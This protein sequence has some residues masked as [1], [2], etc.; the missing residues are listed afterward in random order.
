MRVE[1]SSFQRD[2]VGWDKTSVRVTLPQQEVDAIT[3]RRNLLTK[4][5]D[6][7]SRRK[8]V[9]A[10]LPDVPP[11]PLPPHGGD[12]PA[13]APLPADPAPAPGVADGGPALALVAAGPVGPLATEAAPAPAAPARRKRRRKDV[14]IMAMTTAIQHSC[15]MSMSMG[16]CDIN[17]VRQDK[18]WVGRSLFAPP[19]EVGSTNHICTNLAMRLA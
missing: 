18:E 12:G 19:V 6:R 10:E 14:G 9:P 4:K 8:A 13:P 7:I 17:K 16:V 1:V 2:R 11:V 3:A 5:P 15:V